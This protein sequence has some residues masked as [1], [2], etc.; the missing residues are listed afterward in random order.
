[1]LAKL[2]AG[3]HKPNK[4][5]VIPHDS[6]PQLFSQTNIKK[7]R[8]LGGQLG[9]ILTESLKCDTMGDLLKFSLNQLVGAIGSERG[10]V[11]RCYELQKRSGI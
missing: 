4:Q 9:D 6:V 8:M 10:W 5:T 1:M 2:G 3:M 11:F 7:I